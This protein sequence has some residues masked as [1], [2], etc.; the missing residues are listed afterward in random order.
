M[1]FGPWP[2][3]PSVLDS[4]ANIPPNGVSNFDIVPPWNHEAY[5]V[6]GIGVSITVIGALLRFYVRV[7]VTKKVYLDDCRQ[8]APPS[9]FF[10]IIIYHLRIGIP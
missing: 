3:P 1:A 6:I 4:P 9:V 10:A 2:Y 7:F 8:L 5:A